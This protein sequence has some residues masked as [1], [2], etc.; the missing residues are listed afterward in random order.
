[1]AFQLRQKVL[2]VDLNAGSVQV[3]PENKARISA[4]LINDSDTVMYVALGQ[5]AATNSGVRLNASGGSYEIG[6]TNPWYGE[7]HAYC[8]GATKRLTVIEVSIYATE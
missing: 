8:G 1:M 6:Y 5:A 2:N 3:L 4:I 7:V